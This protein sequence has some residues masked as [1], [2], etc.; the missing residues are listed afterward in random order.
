MLLKTRLICSFYF[1]DYFILFYFCTMW[2]SHLKFQSKFSYSYLAPNSVVAAN[3]TATITKIKVM[4]FTSLNI[5]FQ[6]TLIV[7]YFNQFSVIIF[8]CINPQEFKVRFLILNLNATYLSCVVF[9]FFFLSLYIYINIS[10]F[11]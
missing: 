4:L 6:N 9:F 2:H 11:F 7:I 10:L 5:E 3:D 8:A 1:H